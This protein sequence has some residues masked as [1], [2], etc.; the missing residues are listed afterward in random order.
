MEN[1]FHKVEGMLNNVAKRIQYK[2][3]FVEKC[4]EL[5]NAWGN[6]E[7]GTK[8]NYFMKLRILYDIGSLII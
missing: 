6:T 4:M 1:F 8:R 7:R 3:N 2:E 5:I